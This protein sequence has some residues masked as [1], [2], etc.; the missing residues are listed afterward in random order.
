M[1]Q[2]TGKATAE[3]LT[4]AFQDWRQAEER[5][6]EDFGNRFTSL[7]NT[8]KRAVT[9]TLN[10]I[11]SYF[12]NQ[13]LG[14]MLRAISGGKLGQIFGGALGGGGGL[15]GLLGGAGTSA[16]AGVLMS[17]AG[18]A[19]AAGAAA[20][21]S[22][23]NSSALVGFTPAGA[24][25]G[26]GGLGAA[27]GA[28]FTN[29]WTIGI[30]AAIGVGLLLKKIFGGPSKQELAGRAAREAF[31]APLVARLTPKQ[32][33]EVREGVGQ[34]HSESWMRQAVAVRD[35]YMKR[36]HSA[37]EGLRAFDLL[38]K[39]E[40]RGADAVNQVA[41]QIRTGA[42]ITQ[43]TGSVFS[44]RMG[45]R[46]SFAMG[47]FVPPNTVVP[48]V[49]HGGQF[50]EV[51]TPLKQPANTLG[52]PSVVINAPITVKA[53]DTQDV[54]R[55]MPTIVDELKFEVLHNKRGLVPAISRAQGLV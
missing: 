35:L 29:P 52:G 22:V 8:I 41:N 33:Q 24:A 45:Q 17:A 37:E 6:N 5:A 9:D 23:L 27:M 2:R 11:L 55:G 46:T 14:G 18:G 42:T 13:F 39:A 54:R 15:G 38:L 48:A 34:G 1:I 30:G 21:T 26:G 3:E 19:G 4:R 25:A 51:I 53:W 32:L 31:T 44:G 49:L 36:G 16:G 50:G 20:G 40:K 28:F 10:N 43:P 7:W 47:G 12:T